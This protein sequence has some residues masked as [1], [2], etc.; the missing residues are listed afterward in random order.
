[1]PSNI[2]PAAS[3]SASGQDT[4]KT[5]RETASRRAA[6]TCLPTLAVQSGKCCPFATAFSER[7][8]GLFAAAFTSRQTPSAPRPQRYTD[9]S[10]NADSAGDVRYSARTEAPATPMLH[11]LTSSASN[12]AG[13]RLAA[14]A[15]RDW[16]PAFVTPGLQLRLNP[17]KT[18]TT[19][20]VSTS[21]MSCGAVAKGDAT[22]T[23]RSG[24]SELTSPSVR[25]FPLKS[26]RSRTRERMPHKAETHFSTQPFGP[27]PKPS[28]RTALMLRGS[29]D[30][31][32]ARDVTSLSWMSLTDTLLSFHLDHDAAACATIPATT[33]PSASDGVVR[34]PQAS[35]TTPPPAHGP[36]ASV[37]IESRPH[38]SAS[39]STARTSSADCSGGH[40]KHK[41]TGGSRRRRASK[42]LAPSERSSGG[43]TPEAATE[44]YSCPERVCR[45]WHDRHSA[46]PTCAGEHRFDTSGG[47]LAFSSPPPGG[48][49]LERSGARRDVAGPQICILADTAPHSVPWPPS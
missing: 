17:A 1:M 16:S 20:M 9:N 42:R 39:A 5:R 2:H 48:S 27:S 26:R 47:R 41:S 31:I 30:N 44:R 40:S 28:K 6:A 37:L 19:G 32:D 10:S 46:W 43:N 38:R 25:P 3:S 33:S 7:R 36:T 23:A 12:D 34:Q 49:S 8:V 35:P 21:S 18:G 15:S 22:V 24:E 13:A 11:S 45:R 14:A 4:V 29:A